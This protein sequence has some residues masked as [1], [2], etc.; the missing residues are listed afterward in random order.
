MA[1]AFGCICRYRNCSLLQVSVR[2]KEALGPSEEQIQVKD[3]EDHLNC[4]SSALNGGD[5]EA[6]ALC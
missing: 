2:L 4:R 6:D 3:I 5:K 1:A